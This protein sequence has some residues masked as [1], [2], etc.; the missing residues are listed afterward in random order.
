M[1]KEEQPRER[2]KVIIVENGRIYR[3][4]E[5]MERKSIS[6]LRAEILKS[7]KKTHLG[8][9]QGEEDGQFQQG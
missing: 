1:E 8:R 9:Q 7:K 3:S 4:F 6:E 2:P 5:E